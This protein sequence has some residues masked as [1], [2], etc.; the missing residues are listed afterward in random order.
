[1]RR[2]RKE[3]TLKTVRLYA[4]SNLNS[5][6]GLTN[7]R[8]LRDY[9]MGGSDYQTIEKGNGWTPNFLKTLHQLLTQAPAADIK[10]LRS[11]LQKLLD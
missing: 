7:K 8:V 6:L 1:M 9:P 11:F 5:L 10:R 2:F 3:G 4:Q